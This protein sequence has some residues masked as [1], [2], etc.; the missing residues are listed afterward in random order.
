MHTSSSARTVHFLFDYISHNAYLAWTQIHHIASRHR[1]TVRP[2][3]VLF[4]GF[5]NALK[6]VGPA[7]TPLKAH[8][9]M[10]DCLRKSLRLNVRKQ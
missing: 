2:T 8:W 6:T 7:E 5:L 1:Y 9:M 4:A 3:P 10:R